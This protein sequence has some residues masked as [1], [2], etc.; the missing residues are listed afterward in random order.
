M[1]QGSETG[2]G[3]NAGIISGFQALNSG[4]MEERNGGEPGEAYALRERHEKWWKRVRRRR[5]VDYLFLLA[6]LTPIT[7]ACMKGL[8]QA[9]MGDGEVRREGEVCQSYSLFYQ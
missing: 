8:P 5:D 6:V 7:L 9:S 2:G 1:S 3:T 4:G